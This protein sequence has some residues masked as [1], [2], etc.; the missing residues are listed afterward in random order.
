M[1]RRGVFLDSADE[2]ILKR[3][4][5]QA[6]ELRRTERHAKAQRKRRDLLVAKLLYANVPERMIAEAAKI[7][8]SAVHQLKDRLI[9]NGV[10]DA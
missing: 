6:D 4:R 10:L 2:S 1:A 7:S 9:R 3:L 5:E 8:G